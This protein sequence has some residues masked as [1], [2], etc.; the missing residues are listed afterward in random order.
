MKKSTIKYSCYKY[1]PESARVTVN[2]EKLDLSRTNIPQYI[3][4]GNHEKALAAIKTE[5]RRQAKQPKKYTYIFYRENSK[6]FYYIACLTFT[7][8]DD[9]QSRLYCYKEL[10]HHLQN[11]PQ[12]ITT[13]HGHITP[14]GASKPEIKT[15]YVKIDFSKC[16]RVRIV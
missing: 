10:K 8:A 6:Q 15:E 5:Y 3:A 11:H 9:I 13:E 14:T 1:A 2:G 12:T 4:T 7:A 16:K